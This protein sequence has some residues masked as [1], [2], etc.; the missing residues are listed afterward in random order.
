MNLHILGPNDPALDAL[1]QYLERHPEYEMHL[2]IVA[3]ENYQNA[4]FDSLQAIESPYQ[5]VFIPGHVWLAELVVEGKLAPLPVDKISSEI[6]TLYQPDD[7]LPKI[8]EECQFDKEPYLIPYFTDG[9]LLFYRNDIMSIEEETNSIP[10]IAPQQFEQLVHKVHHPPQI[11]G[12]ALKAAPS[13]IFLD[14]LPFLWAFGGD[15]LD[16]QNKPVIYSKESLLALESYCNLRQYCPQ[17]VQGYGNFEIAA[18]LK[19]QIVCLAPTWGGQAASIFANPSSEYPYST[20]LY[21]I[22]W[23]ATWGIGI[24][25]N[26]SSTQ[27]IRVTEKLYQ[28]NR[29][30]MDQ[31]VL[32]IAGSPVR[33]STYSA[34]NF[35]KFFWLKAQGEMLQRCRTLPAIPQLGKILGVLYAAVYTAFC[36]E[37]SSRD[38]L[39]EAQ[40]ALESIL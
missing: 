39:A 16:D 11:Y 7:I 21:P 8:R 24:P 23:N 19:N 4:L 36:G 9:H 28:I 3:W 29:S 25:N 12:L 15:V 37:K 17:D 14:W 30:E 27:K 40:T 22:P 13:E 2:T 26:Q 32:E 6:Y 31:K 10:T 5:A 34:A 35:E 38:V 1:S 33:R 18:A 20:A